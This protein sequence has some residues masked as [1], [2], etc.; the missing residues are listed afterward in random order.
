MLPCMCIL[1]NMLVIAVCITYGFID[2]ELI[3]IIG[4]SVNVQAAVERPYIHILAAGSSSAADNVA[5][6]ADRVDCLNEWRQTLSTADGTQLSDVLRFFS[7]DKVAQWME[8]GC[9]LGGNYK[10]GSCGIE[11]GSFIDSACCNQT[12]YRSL[13]DI[14]THVLAGIH[15][16]KRLCLKPFS[17]LSIQEVRQELAARHLDSGGDGKIARQRLTEHLGGL[18]RVPLLLITNP[19]S[20]LESLSLQ[21]YAINDFEPLH[22]IKGHFINLFAELPYIL[23]NNIKPD[24][25]QLLRS[26]LRKEKVTGA[27]LRATAIVLFKFLSGK[28]ATEIE[29]LIE[30][31]VRI[32]EISYLAEHKRTPRSILQ[33]YNCTWYHHELL[34]SL[35]PQPHSITRHKLFGSYLHDISCHAAPQFE[36]VSLKSCNTEFEERLFGQV[37]RVAENCSNRQPQNVL[38]QVFIRLQVL[39]NQG[40]MKIKE[41]KVVRA[42]R[43]LKP[44][45]GTS[46]PKNFLIHRMSSW[47]VHLRR[48]SPYLSK[49]EGVWWTQTNTMYHF[50]DGEHHP[51]FHSQGPPLQNFSNLSRKQLDNIKANQWENILQNRLTLPTTYVQLYNNLGI[52]TEKVFFPSANDTLSSPSASPTTG[53][54]AAQLLSTPTSSGTTTQPITLNLSNPLQDTPQDNTG[55]LTSAELESSDDSE[56]DMQGMEKRHQNFETLG[57][58][59]HI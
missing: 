8:G 53:T 32:A 25:N 45:A 26:C 22:G 6:A 18:Q 1:Y 42:A 28:V 50:F 15:G 23:P 9:Q 56:D 20:S 41:S 27:D 30:S 2:Y 19:K 59:I 52:P 3:I 11:I 47:Q 57:T 29:A 16:G 33:L 34:L 40:N 58:Y 38:N 39:L 49:G 36:L 31:A 46:I 7:G 54:H 51:N 55:S 17:G 4:E 5:L 48:I 43:G 10:C 44:Y 12:P 24:V 13:Q 14:Q 21:H 37:R 35:I